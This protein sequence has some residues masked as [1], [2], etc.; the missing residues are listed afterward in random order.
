MYNNKDKLCLMSL[1]PKIIQL[2]QLLGSKL[3]TLTSSCEF[4]S[5][6]LPWLARSL[7][8][9]FPKGSVVE[10]TSGKGGVG[11]FLSSIFH[12]GKEMNLKV[13][14]IDGKDSFD[15]QSYESKDLERVLWL[16]CREAG[17]A[18]KAA[19]LLLRDGNLPLIIL[20]LKSNPAAE[21]R[22]IPATT[23]F[24]FQRLGEGASSVLIVLTASP[25][26]GS[27]VIRLR[28]E[29]ELKLNGLHEFQESLEKYL[30]IEL[31]KEK[32]KR[33]RAVA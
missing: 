11:L 21:L 3:K 5:L 17:Q 6:D 7:P 13:A 29:A 20:D 10:V 1:S 26:V 8:Q 27:A 19:D 4:L 31:E 28:V 12:G 23:W 14:L 32:N 15:P 33:E 25:M 2:Q 18:L 30:I 24:R 9:G 22:K 16:R